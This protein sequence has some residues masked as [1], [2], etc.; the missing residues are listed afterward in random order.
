[1]TMMKFFLSLL[2][3]CIFFL[4]LFWIPSVLA[5]YQ[6]CSVTI[7]SSDEIEAFKKHLPE[8]DFDF[9]ELIPSEKEE[10][11]LQNDTHWFYEACKRG[12]KCDILVISGH[13]GGTFFGESKHI[14]PIELMEEHSCKKSC[15]G[16]LSQAKEIFLFGCNTLSNK[17]KDLRTSSEYLQV[18]L[19]DGM[20]R[21]HAER[22]V[23]SRYS[24]LEISFYNRMKFVFSGSQAI[25]GFDTLSPLGA[26]IYPYLDSYF[27]SINK[28]F[29]NYKSY[30]DEKKYKR[31][32][33]KE[34]FKTL[35]STSLSQ[36]H[37]YFKNKKDKKIFH[38]KC[39]VYNKE[40]SFLEKAKAIQ[41]IF[42]E[43]NSDLAFFAIDY[44][45]NN[46]ETNFTKGEGK[47]IFRSIKNNKAYQQEFKSIY[48]KI[49][50]L[51]YL[52][53]VYL[54][55]LQKLRW[56]SITDFTKEVRKNV[57]DLI[58]KPDSE[59]YEVL[60]LLK[61]SHYLPLK[62]LYITEEDIPSEY[63]Y[64]FWGL[65]ILEQLEIQAPSLHSGILKSCF[66]KIDEDTTYC[67]Q[68][69]VTIGSTGITKEFINELLPLLQHKD[70]GIIFY[71]LKALGK[72]G[73]KN[74]LVHNRILYFLNY[75]NSL[76]QKEALNS[77]KTLKTPYRSIHNSI[78]NFLN[79]SDRKWTL[80][81]LK[82]LTVMNVQSENTNEGIVQALKRYPSD[83]EIVK[84]GI[85]VF[86]NSTKL[87]VIL[88][89][90][91]YTLLDDGDREFKSF[92]VHIMTRTKSKD[93]GIF[94]RYINLLKDSNPL[95]K[96][97]ILTHLG[98][99]SWFHPELQYLIIPYLLNEDQIMRRLVV[100][101]FRN[102]ENWSEKTIDQIKTLHGKNEEVNNLI[103]HLK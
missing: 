21:E 53:I 20:A 17:D 88:L 3:K 22:V 28:T 19:D 63:P 92:V 73:S 26:N 76:I 85:L 36:A 1:M 91:I 12:L 27:H 40:S 50:N 7:N 18:L 79:F 52:R 9:V 78:S 64:D 37:S 13:F 46:Y 4:P 47:S 10:Y 39:L 54:N 95:F 94:Y 97:E 87:P 5:K 102:V 14:L 31:D 68:A 99:L 23:S 8:S 93:I 6:I 70:E 45:L 83:Q 62:S 25:Y 29:G 11:Y 80:D 72:S 61:S 98:H 84:T 90:Y 77:L 30:L 60:S 67:Y 96:K 41:N 43:N 35:Q 42:K 82:A 71:T 2:Q 86:K 24:P 101:L 34:L 49:E 32:Q 89:D 48:N 16:I 44:F 51:P 69:L 103:K 81:I 65:L 56:V 75:N 100:D 58:Q 38:N 57:L 55:I 59:T 74:H 33:N 66:N 15:S